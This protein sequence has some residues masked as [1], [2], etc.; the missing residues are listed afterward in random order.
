M[1]RTLEPGADG[2]GRDNWRSQLAALVERKER[3]ERTSVA[4]FVTAH[5]V[6]RM[7]CQSSIL[8]EKSW[9]TGARTLSVETKKS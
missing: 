9:T 6:C 1:K 7:D 2:N 8:G 4:L 5:R 3:K